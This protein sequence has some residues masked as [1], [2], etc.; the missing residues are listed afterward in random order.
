MPKG[1]HQALDVL[2]PQPDAKTLKPIEVSEGVRIVH[3]SGF[4]VLSFG[5]MVRAP[6]F[7]AHGQGS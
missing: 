1:L 3:G 2:K 5:F 7:R 6:R 4:R